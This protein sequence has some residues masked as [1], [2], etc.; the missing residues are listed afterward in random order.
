MTYQKKVQIL[1]E[2]AEGIQYLHT[3]NRIH[4]DIKVP[5]K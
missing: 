2:I 1:V 5:I 3:N 4:R